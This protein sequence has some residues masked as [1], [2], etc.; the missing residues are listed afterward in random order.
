MPA[1]NFGEVGFR[2]GFKM[3]VVTMDSARSRGSAACRIVCR[4]ARHRAARRPSA[5][6]ELP[7]AEERSEA[8]HLGLLPEP[9]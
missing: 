4:G 2:L 9:R 1:L 8:R 7:Q 5:R 6:Q 3:A